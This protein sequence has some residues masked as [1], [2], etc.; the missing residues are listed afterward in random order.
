M[1]G[2]TQLSGRL[3]PLDANN[4][5]TDQIIPKQFLTAVSRRGFGKHLFFDWR[6][7]DGDSQRPNPDFSL[8]QPEY[9][10]ANVLLSKANFG[11]GSSREHAPWALTDYGFKAVI[12]S[13]FADIFYGNSLNNQLL[14]IALTDSQVDAL[15]AELKTD[16]HVR[17]NIDLASQTVTCGQK[18]YTFEINPTH[19]DMLMSGLDTIGQTLAHENAI[20]DF[21]DQL[22]EWLN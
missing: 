9:Q 20:K 15:F 12:A 16:S 1:S 3:A 4:V 14:C 6:Y 2:F 13:S 19:K 11:C 10:G 5:D 22:P 18:Q 7:L 8:N 17:I 21:E